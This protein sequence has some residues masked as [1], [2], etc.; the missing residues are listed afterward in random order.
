MCLALIGKDLSLLAAFRDPFGTDR[1]KLRTPASDPDLEE[2]R[3]QL[4]ALRT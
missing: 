1:A 2:L 4:E 3:R